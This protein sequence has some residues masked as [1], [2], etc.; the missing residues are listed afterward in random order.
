MLFTWHFDDYCPHWLVH[1]PESNNEFMVHLPMF[2]SIV[3]LVIW[4]IHCF[5]CCK[6]NHKVAK[7]SHVSKQH[8]YVESPTYIPRVSESFV[9]GWKFSLYSITL[10]NTNSEIMPQITI[11]NA[12]GWQFNCHIDCLA[13]YLPGIILSL[14]HFCIHTHTHKYSR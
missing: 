7:K 3:M 13:G 6:K 1:H 11:Q 4:F 9:L 10:C 12:S 8:P 5:I 14:E 2:D